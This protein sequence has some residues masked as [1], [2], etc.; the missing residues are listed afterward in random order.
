GNLADNAYKWARSRVQVH[1]RNEP[2]GRSEG[3]EFTL[4]VEDDGPGI[5]PDQVERVRGRG[6]RADASTPGHGLGIAVVQEMTELYGGD[7]V[8]SRSPLGGAAVEVRL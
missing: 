2:A 8:I 7:L 3:R 4:R 6:A 5:A 1:A